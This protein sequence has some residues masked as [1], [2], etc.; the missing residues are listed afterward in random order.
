MLNF[1][2]FIFA[3]PWILSAFVILPAI[4]WLLRIFPPS[5][6]RIKS[7]TIRLILGIEEKEPVADT[8]PW[9]L[10]ALRL[11]V[12]SLIILGLAHPILNP[13]QNLTNEG[14][15]MLVVDDGWA[16]AQHWDRKMAVANNLVD[17]ANREGRS[18][19]ILTTAARQ[20]GAEPAPLAELS[21]TD[22]HGVLEALKPKPWPAD[23]KAAMDL[24][25]PLPPGKP[26][27]IAWISDGLDNGK[28]RD[29]AERLQQLGTLELFQDRPED[30]PP[31][32]AGVESAADGFDVSVARAPTTLPMLVWV[33]VVDAEG[34]LLGRVN[35]T[36][37]AGEGSETERLAIP[38]ELRN[39][40]ARL[41]IEA[42]GTAAGV[43][44]LDDRVYRR[45]VG[46]VGS[47]ATTAQPLL[48][49]THYI[50]S[51]V[52]PFADIKADTIQ[53]VLDAN[54]DVVILTDA[55]VIAREAADQLESW[56]TRGGLLL[57]FAGPRLAERGNRL[58]PV[59]L[60]DGARALGG[61]MTWSS[62]AKLAPF[63]RSSPFYGI[64]IP[65]DVEIRQQVLAEPSA[66]LA[67]KTW[68]KLEDGTPLIT[69]EPVGAGWSILVHTTANPDW[70]NLPL[71]G[72]FV[73]MMQRIIALA[74]GVAALPANQ[75]SAPQSASP[76]P[77]SAEQMLRPVTSLD[78]FGA[79]GAPLSGAQPIAAS[80][81][82]TT[83]AGPDHPPGF[84]AAPGL[85]RAVNLASPNGPISP[86]T[87]LKAI[88]DLP[89]GIILSDYD[90]GQE[91]DLRAALLIAAVTLAVLDLF[92]ALL[93]GG[94]LTGLTRV[95]L[96]AGIGSALLS[97][98]T[99]RAADAAAD[100]AA[101][102]LHL[103]YVQTGDIT[104]DRTSRAGLQ[105]LSDVLQIRTSVQPDAPIGIS[106]ARD[107]LTFFP[108]IY[109]PITPD[110]STPSDS[111]L[112]KIRAYLNNG[113]TILFDTRDG[114]GS[115]ALAAESVAPP[116]TMAL[117]KIL[118]ALGHAQLE[119]PDRDHVLTRTFYLIRQFPGRYSDGQIWLDHTPSNFHDGVSSVIAGGN[120]WASA[121]ASDSRGAPTSA[122]VEGGERQR[123]FAYRFGVN[124]VMYVLT[125]NYKSDQVHVPFLLDRL[126]RGRLQ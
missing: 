3:N 107:E 86:N 100:A 113:G 8:T 111:S 110:Q 30:L 47:E 19:L 81:L 55:D 27:H 65:D 9:W 42:S 49:D 14:P 114:D 6:E 99:A 7:P 20:S 54:V 105:G 2:P 117:R 92:I 38:V 50:E 43:A 34:R 25:E 61:A 67:A 57:Q 123:E 15:L 73:D 23:R 29:F 63:D 70:S 83:A 26:Y 48:T 79:L 109:W 85:R 62:P 121:W 11:L 28:A 22:A 39:R 112:A 10:V 13:N 69:A 104:V 126:G 116:A 82:R 77:G 33:I 91:R 51:A 72:L 90:S 89:G 103:A 87:A 46:L 101:L 4:W 17:Q 59:P 94:R 78:G 68:A 56:M 31:V 35:V 80:A 24:L 84:Y 12:V 66:D 18:V 95:I 120:D 44:L 108:L 21:P 76:A 97:G 122:I 32:V 74:N 125:G 5:P 88:A 75:A 1:G 40:A 71:S 93:L 58:L 98:G 96:I 36:A 53:G 106:I 41:E 16:G 52:K 119:P 102:S 118:A 115:P 60:R 37:Q 64:D 45:K 124:L